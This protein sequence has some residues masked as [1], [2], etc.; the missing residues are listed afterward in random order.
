M[1]FSGGKPCRSA[2]QPLEY[3]MSLPE[4]GGICRKQALFAAAFLLA[5]VAPV[6]AWGAGGEGVSSG[7]AEVSAR[8]RVESAKFLNFSAN[9]ISYLTGFNW[10]T[11][12]AQSSRRDLVTLEHF[13]DN[14]LGDLFLFLDVANLGTYGRGTPGTR[15]DVYGEVSP[16]L[17]LS[18]LRRRAPSE[19]LIKD[20][21]PYAGTLE[22][23][24]SGS[25]HH[26]NKTFGLSLDTTHL[27]QLHGVGVDLNLPGF[28]F[29]NLN[30]Y[31]RDTQDV[32]G[33]TWQVTAAW[34]R[35]FRLGGADFMFKGFTDLAG[36]EGGLATM[37]HVSPQLLFDAGAGLFGRKERLWLGV[38]LDAW[39]NE[40][41]VRGQN[42]FVP[43]LLL[44]LTF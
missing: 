40:Y 19:G 17:S 23:G 14:R 33:S 34:A 9:S 26:L 44:Q 30:A 5:V 39:V 31:W 10:Q 36:P 41:G 8:K 27:G 22:F 11:P 1:V 18:K 37:L 16:R 20:F 2:F 3:P 7:E 42:D 29:A 32:P 28:R 25:L 4:I 43:Q 35:P 15:V 12:F 24:Y 21:L 38:E 6:V 13:N